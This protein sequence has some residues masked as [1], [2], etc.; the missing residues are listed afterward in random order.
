[1]IGIDTNIL[2]RVFLEDDEQQSKLAQSFLE[3]TAKT[4]GVFISSYALLEFVWVL[5]VKGFTRR[6]IQK[7][8]VTLCDANGVHI[9]EKEIVLSAIEKYAKGIADFGDYMILSSGEN[10]KTHKLKTFDLA[11]LKENPNQCF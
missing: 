7:A 3:N 8:L 4:E 11:L 1:M 6:E 2:A 10:N 9:G 5:K